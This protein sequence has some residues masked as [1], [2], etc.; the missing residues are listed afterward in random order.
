MK[1][2]KSLILAGIVAM[3]VLVT[4]TLFAQ[5]T[6]AQGPGPQEAQSVAAVVGSKISYQGMLKENGSPVN[7]TRTITFTL[8][9]DS[10]CA[11]AKQT[12]VRSV[13]ITNGLFTTDLD[14]NQAHF[15]SQALWL[16]SQVG[17]TQIGCQEIL[18]VPYALSLRPK[19]VISSTG[20]VLDDLFKVQVGDAVVKGSMV[21]GL[22]FGSAGVYGYA[23]DLPIAV[24]VMGT[25]DGNVYD[26][27]GVWGESS[28]TSNHGRG[29]YGKGF[30]GVYG[31]T[32]SNTNGA[33]GYFA[34]DV[35]QGRT[36]DGLVKAGA[37]VYCS[38][39]ASE[40]T[41]SFNNVGGTVSV[42][43]GATTGPG[44]CTI[45]FGFNI[46]DRYFV[47]TSVSSTARGASC[48]TSVS[49]P[50]R[51]FC[52]PWNDAGTSLDGTIMVLIY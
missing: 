29:V 21:H 7:G 18:P 14:V 34:G 49:Y 40:L 48:Y 32:I 5:L 47:A 28:S 31:E 17:A 51:L 22:L 36:D 1:T 25:S 13:P 9:S 37:Y 26:N 24:G 39:T 15:D 35:K 16:G 3:A 43:N 44:V 38:S 45:D 12:I 30:Y 8:A 20:D 2:R 41:R 33:A 52:L 23:E 46:F 42:S 11:T 50:N 4:L 6:Q 19:A 10:S 27:W